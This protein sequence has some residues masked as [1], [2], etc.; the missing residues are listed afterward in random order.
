[1]F[2]FVSQFTTKNCIFRIILHSPSSLALFNP[3]PCAFPTSTPSELLQNDVAAWHGLAA[4][5]R[6][7]ASQS[8]SHSRLFLSIRQY[9][10]RHL[11]GSEGYGRANGGF[12]KCGRE[13]PV[14]RGEPFR[15]VHGV[16]AIAHTC[17]HVWIECLN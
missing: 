15:V 14:E 10:T 7:R 3:I 13:P 6:A 5:P 4:F 16:K 2:T 8:R 17:I 11:E 9:L 1:M 12:E